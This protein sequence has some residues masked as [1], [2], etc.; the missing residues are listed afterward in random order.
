MHLSPTDFLATIADAIG[1][2]LLSS[3]ANDE[4]KTLQLVFRHKLLPTNRDALVTL[5]KHYM[6]GLKAT[7]NL[8]RRTITLTARKTARKKK[9]SRPLRELESEAGGL[10]SVSTLEAQKEAD[11][12]EFFDASPLEES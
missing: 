10:F 6:P 1:W 2:N 8:K 9:K 12:A 4:K 7:S 5:A 3:A 11:P